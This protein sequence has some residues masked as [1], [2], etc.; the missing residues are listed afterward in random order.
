MPARRL[1][2]RRVLQSSWARRPPAA[3]ANWSAKSNP[4]RC[5]G[6]V[7]RVMFLESHR[8]RLLP[9]L[10]HGALSFLRNRAKREARHATP[11]AGTQAKAE[12]WLA[13]KSR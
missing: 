9:R 4:K 7:A 8:V 5:V 11:K 10:K 13:L 2:A 1:S 3:Y 12:S 6:T